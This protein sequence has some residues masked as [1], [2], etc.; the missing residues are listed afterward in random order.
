MKKMK[1][2][3]RIISVCIIL[4][5]LLAS[6]PFDMFG[7]MIK[8][9][10][11]E[12]PASVAEPIPAV[13]RKIKINDDWRFQL[14]DKSSTINNSLDGTAS[15]TNYT[16]SGTW[17]MVQLPH[18]WSIYQPFAESD[19]V[20]RPAQGSLPG[21]TGW[22]RKT[23]TISN[24]MK[25]KNVV[26]QFDA[27][28]MVSEVWINGMNL[29]KQYLGYVTFEYDITKYLHFDGQENVIA[30]KAFASN[31]SA[32]WY[33][34]AGIYGNVYLIATDKVHIPVNGIH[35]A[36]VVEEN[37]KYI[38]PDFHTEPDMAALKAKS[39]VNVRTNVENKTNAAATV[40][41][42]SVIYNDTNSNVATKTDNINVPATGNA[43]VDQLIN[44]TNPKLWNVDDP[45]LYWVKTE[46][47][48]DGKVVDTMDTRFGIRYLYLKPGSYVEPYSTSNTL[49][50]LYING[51]YTRL[52]GVCEHRD[53]G[54]LGMETYQAGVER[55]IRKLKSMGVNVIRCA[56]NPVSTEYIEAADKLGMLIFEEG[57]DQWIAAKNT[58]DYSNYF[59]KAADGT[60]VVFNRSA[61][62]GE[63]TYIQ[64]VRPDLTPNCVRDI[65]AMVDRD[66]NSPSIF[67]WSTG[68]EI[69]DSA[70][71]HGMDTQWLLSAAIKEIDSLDNLPYTNVIN[72]NTN[73][74]IR[75]T[76]AEN[77]AALPSAANNYTTD[78]SVRGGGARYGRPVSAA[79]PTWDTGSNKVTK[80]N[81]FI[82]NMAMADIGG[83]N[84]SGATNQYSA[85][86]LR[87]P[88]ASVLGTETSSSFYTRGVY[89]I[90]D[91]GKGGEEGFRGAH[92][93]GYASEWPFNRNFKT[94]SVT[95]RE[96]REDMMPF[97]FGEMVWT[98]HDYLGEPT[99]HSRPSRSS[100]FGI[101]DTAGFEKDAFYMYRSAWTDIPTV[102]LLPQK[103]N[104]DLG[105]QVPIM[106]YTNAASVEVFINNKSIGVKKYDKKTAN[107]VYLDYGYCEYQPGEL[108]AVA[109]DKDGK[110]IATDVVYTAGE[111][112]SI[113]LTGDR[114]FIKNDGNDL[115]YVEAEIVDS[116]GNML[117][118]ANNRITFNVQG[119][120][121]VALD[122]GDPR[123]TEPFRGTNNNNNSNTS[124][125]RRAFNG[126]ALAIIKATKGSVDDIV[127]TAKASATGGQ[128]V[129]NE[130][131]AGA[132]PEIGDGTKLQSYEELEITT[133]VGVDPV[134]PETVGA[135][136]DNG[137]IAPLDVTAWDLSK[138]DLSKIGTYSAYA[139]VTGVT[140]LV[141]AKIHVKSI[142]SIDRIEVTT[143]AGVEPSLPNFVTLHYEDGK[144]GSTEVTWDAISTS[145]YEDE[146]IFTVTG[147]IDSNVSVFADV[148]VK[149]LLSIDDI[150]INTEIGQLPV[151]PTTVM[152]KFTDDSE[153]MLGVRWNIAQSD[154]ASAGVRKITGTVLGSDIKA[155]AFLNVSTVVYASDLSWTAQDNVKKDQMLD[156]ASL[157][158]RG[159]QG[160]PGEVYEKGIGTKAP[161]EIK[162]DIAGKGYERF[163][164]FVNLSLLN[165]GVVAPGKVAF[166]VYLD[167]ST[168]PV[169]SSGDM[170]SA[171]EAKVVDIDVTGKST[172]RLVTES[173]SSNSEV[174]LGDWVDAKFLSANIVVDEVVMKKLYTNKVN[175][176]PTLPSTVQAKVSG[177][178]KLVN[179][180]VTWLS[181]MNSTA[182]TSG[183]VRTIYGKLQGAADG[184]VAVKVITDYGSACMLG[185]FGSKVG[186]WSE[187]ENFDYP[188]N[189]DAK[190]NLSTA[191][192]QPKLIY[193]ATS[194]MVIE[195]V[196]KYGFGYSLYPNAVGSSNQV[197]F[198]APDLNYF[199][200]QNVASS[201]DISNN[202]NF[203]FETSTDGSN[204]TSFTAVTKGDMISDTGTTTVWAR[205]T[206]TSNEN[207][208]FPSGTNFLR[209]T[210]PSDS[211]W[212]Y[213]MTSITL[214]GGSTTDIEMA[215]FT[216][217]DYTGIIDQDA[218]TITVAV[219]GTFDVTNVTPKILVSSGATV[220]PTGPQN[221]TNPV[222]YTV[223][224]G[225]ITKT[226]TVTVKRGVNANFSLYGGNI[227]GNKQD[228]TYFLPKG[229]MVQ[230]PTANPI[231][232]NFIF[233]GWTTDRAS[234]EPMSVNQVTINEDTTFYAIWNKDPYLPIKTNGDASLKTYKDEKT[235]N[236]GSDTT[237]LSRQN[238]NTA[239]YGLFGENFDITSTTDTSDMKTDLIRF[240]LE[241]LNGMEVKSA[242]LALYYEGNQNPASTNNTKFIVNRAGSDW[243]E[244]GVTWN[245]R[246]SISATDTTVESEEFSATGSGT[247]E[248]ELDVSNIYKNLTTGDKQITFAVTANSNACDYKLTSKEGATGAN[249][250]RA[251][252]LI[253]EVDRGT[254]YMVTYDLNG[255]EGKAPIQ[256]TMF[257]GESFKAATGNDITGPGVKKFAGWNT[258]AN[259][260][261]IGYR[262][263][264]QVVM[265]AGELKLYAVY[266]DPVTITPNNKSITSG[267]NTIDLSTLGLFTIDPNAGTTHT[268]SVVSGGTGSGRVDSSNRK[269]LNVLEQGT[270]RI[271]LVTSETAT[272]VR[273]EAIATLN[274]TIQ[275]NPD[276]DNADITAA[277]TAIT[278]KTFT[279]IQSNVSTAAAAKAAVETMISGLGEN[280]KG[281]TTTVIDVNN[282]FKAAVAGAAASP[283]GTNGSYT[284][285]VE[286]TKDLGIKQTTGELTLTITATKYAAPEENKYNV[287]V[288]TVNVDQGT[289][290]GGQTNVVAGASVTVTATA[291][292][293]YGFAGWYNGN[294]L[295]SSDASY[296]FVV[297]TNVS[298]E[299]RWKANTYTLNFKKG[300]SKASGN[301]SAKN[302]ISQYK[303]VQNDLNR[304]KL[305]GYIPTAFKV[306]STTYKVGSTIRLTSNKTAT[307][308]Y[309]KVTVGKANK[310][311][312]SN[313]KNGQM[314][315]KKG[316]AVSGAKGYQV[317]YA[318]NSRFTKK[319]KSLS[320]FTVVK[321][322][323]KG[324]TYY[325]RVRAYKLDSKG[326]K[327][328]GTWSPTAKLKIR[329]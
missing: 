189:V 1:D 277:K 237:L 297:N 256:S 118:T 302:N 315:I 120:E 112:K 6:L 134:L 229:S 128:I 97:I 30:V 310:A 195:N 218:G 85:H 320:K 72:T 287:T 160:G 227:D 110:I 103:W 203:T 247:K 116:A 155:T 141:E 104:W 254:D 257:A 27:V 178:E 99:P 209:V 307:V 135:I 115:L 143:I 76:A 216:L 2:L 324:T 148:T 184:V 251:P 107:P 207:A 9:A 43:K 28:Q 23:F 11:A 244:N 168:E 109:K 180:N 296:T 286:L 79:P 206:F 312:L 265:P 174:D 186:K 321:K 249:E 62:T 125:N 177:V 142:A 295:V 124:N 139:S 126:K 87:Y 162:I 213:N 14:L 146:G 261:G 202:S 121:I 40:T 199:Q 169:F 92:S 50:G 39:T 77:Y 132:E 273:G 47:I 182:F 48:Q 283:D 272:H 240:N 214:K 291:K 292:T 262:V 130:L 33:A 108:K 58:D 253:V 258:V 191:T 263:G 274:V 285:T 163:R 236:F 279:T 138:V 271:K 223:S 66:K 309:T 114:S 319:L 255:G 41:V 276:Q 282:G 10:S 301:L 94:A 73:R 133:R 16:E 8:V 101:I 137:L 150:T 205:R 70:E 259:G 80:T 164:S 317:Q 157:Q 194:G 311:K 243:L 210:Y 193:S 201:A 245:T 63:N 22:Y 248:I 24:D 144:T 64:W 52:N 270:I 328:Y 42:K 153:E 61:S 55:R 26:L 222:T 90:S 68:N 232:E 69:Y 122:N 32:R 303:V 45:N 4:V 217:G 119:G 89:N 293:G 49:G 234:K 204:W 167:D 113:A 230:A 56:H 185:D 60:T 35:V 269:T 34:G 13:E 266:K 67:M 322:L 299:A 281:V 212:Q 102:H 246:P 238:N 83:H 228:I 98:G 326:K 36:T 313:P 304:F 57:F 165:G 300:N 75:P 158:A 316:K 154:V 242:K 183:T 314:Q 159:M 117:P 161:A 190:M 289:V 298:L 224:K 294:T 233:G 192:M 46:I 65:Q 96:H 305:K 54:A 100:Y 208:T 29:G 12:E 21:G 173:K 149:K 31:S 308:V 151:M 44:I 140:E 19:S 327:V 284:F 264:E 172:I 131:V 188:I 211:S 306:G 181:S 166:K 93:S 179:F 239:S 268:Y 38:L 325:V 59:N 252:R 318:A 84:Y 74:T 220:S 187:T 91:Y 88:N 127:V 18:D 226:Y 215:D 231:R 156:G 123:D 198:A 275:E 145:E 53:L 78:Y 225:D 267:T 235:R 106:V 170:N 278:G 7:S 197:V 86:K 329:K 290:S 20:A 51:K 111:A 260:T 95:I 71:G 219:P 105:T 171:N 200:I 176:I 280:L 147:K 196:Q 288:T 129:S 152:V 82:D 136:Y 5:M 81:G 17:D 25:E 221:F 241:Q 15:Q 250:S 37:G 3:K 175:Q 323:K